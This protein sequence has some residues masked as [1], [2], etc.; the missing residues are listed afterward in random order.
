MA[1]KPTLLRDFGITA[2]MVR[3][4][5][6]D[7]LISDATKLLITDLN[8]GLYIGSFLIECIFSAPQGYS[9][10]PSNSLPLI[11]IKYSMYISHLHLEPQVDLIFIS[12]LLSS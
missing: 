3:E 2:T 1:V 8:F 6:W 11:S 12:F 9:S 7:D 4:Y 5:Q 10:Y